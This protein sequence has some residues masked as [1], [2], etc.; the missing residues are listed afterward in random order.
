M[1]YPV[2]LKGEFVGFD[3]EDVKTETAR[4]NNLPKELRKEESHGH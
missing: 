1:S 2:T 3:I 4:Y